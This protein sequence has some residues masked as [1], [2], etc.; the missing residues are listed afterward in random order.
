MT[1][2]PLP[3]AVEAAGRAVCRIGWDVPAERAAHFES[4]SAA[5]AAAEPVIRQH[6]RQQVA[7]VLAMTASLG[8]RPA[9]IAYINRFIAS[10]RG[11][12]DG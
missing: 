3:D 2:V 1:E 9:L 7:D 10:N 6:E 12:V 5:V 11:D 4:I 8:D